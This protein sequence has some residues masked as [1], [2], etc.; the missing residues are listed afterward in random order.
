MPFKYKKSS[1]IVH[2]GLYDLGKKRKGACVKI[3][4]QNNYRRNESYRNKAPF[5]DSLLSTNNAL[6][7]AGTATFISEFNN[8]NPLTRVRKH[9]LYKVLENISKTTFNKWVSY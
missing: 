5:V 8:K 4:K 2:R 1:V 9:W 6:F 3:H 7:T